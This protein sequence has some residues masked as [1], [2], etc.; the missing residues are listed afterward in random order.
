MMKLFVMLT[1]CLNLAFSH[2]LHASD[3][4]KW[5]TQ[6]SELEALLPSGESTWLVDLD[7]PEIYEWLQV[8]YEERPLCRD[9]N[10]SIEVYV[11]DLQ[12]WYQ[13]K[14]VGDSYQMEGYMIDAVRVTFKQSELVGSFCK[15]SLYGKIMTASI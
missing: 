8:R 7:A 4:D 1:L 2:S 15:L 9:L 14:L 10:Y 12:E 5:I 6:I 13:A 3:S 11:P